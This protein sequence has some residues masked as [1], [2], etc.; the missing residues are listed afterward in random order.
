MKGPN[1][2]NHRREENALSDYICWVTSQ[3]VNKTRKHT[4]KGW[5]FG[6]EWLDGTT[7][8]VSLKDLKMDH[9]IELAEYCENSNLLNE[10]A[11]AWWAPHVIKKRANIIGKVKARSKKK[12]QKYGIA[13]PRSVKE[14]LELDRVNQNTLW[15]DAIAKDMKNVR[16][17]F[18]ILE[19]GRNI[20]PGRTYLECYLIF[21]VKMDF[22]RKARFIA[23]GSKTPDLLYATYAGVVSR[24]SVRIAFTYV[25]LHDLDVMAGDIQDAYL[26]APISEKYW[27]ISGPEFGSELEDCKVIIVRALFI[28]H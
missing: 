18:D 2:I 9:P 25:A 1:I 26:T 11:I 23:N 19:D 6:V 5:Y 14:A 8:W 13:V 12:S 22:T 28:R 16:I 27:T 17:A 3:N 4:T 7:S 21:D 10:A 15:R 20:E 24:E